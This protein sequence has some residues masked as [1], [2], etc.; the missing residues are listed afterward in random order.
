MRRTIVFLIE[1][2]GTNYSGWQRQKNSISIQ[3]TIEKAIEIV[4]HKKI[5]VIGAGRTDAGVHA[6]AQVAHARI[7][8]NFPI[9]EKKLASAINSTLPPDIRILDA[10]II[11]SMFHATKDAIAREYLYLVSTTNTVFFRNYALYFPFDLD[12]NLLNKSAEIFIGEH[13]FTPFA[14][15]NPSTKSYICCVEISNWKKLSDNLFLYNIKAN[16]FVYGLVRSL[17]GIMLDVARGR[18]NIEEVRYALETKVKKFPSPLAKEKGLFLGKVYY[19][20]EKEIFKNHEKNFD[21][22]KILLI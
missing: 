22:K 2:D 13:D 17:V 15:K 20:P 12:L 16:R 8:N 1:Y 4:S 10:K 21:F 5:F 14:K 3:E 19:P 11:D 18:R 9:P 7:D 6:L